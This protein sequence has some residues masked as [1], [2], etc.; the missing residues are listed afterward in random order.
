MV[1][2]RLGSKLGK[3]RF[4]VNEAA[5]HIAKKRETTHDP[6]WMLNSRLHFGGLP[7]DVI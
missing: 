2:R 1:D 3:V 7:S 4:W 5:C 6:D